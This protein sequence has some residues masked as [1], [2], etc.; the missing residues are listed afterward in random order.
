MWWLWI[1]QITIF[2]LQDGFFICNTSRKEIGSRGRWAWIEKFTDFYCDP[3]SFLDS[4]SIN[5]RVVLVYLKV[6][7]LGLD[8]VSFLLPFLGCLPWATPAGCDWPTHWPPACDWGFL[9]EHPCD[10]FL[11]HRLPPQA[12]RHCHPLQQ[13]GTMWYLSPLHVLVN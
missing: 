4:A 5:K 3:L 8:Q 6:E 10:C 13:Q 2:L 9:C 1:K 12:R 11:Q 7:D